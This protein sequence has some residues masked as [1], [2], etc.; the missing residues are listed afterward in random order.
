MRI[1]FSDK[2]YDL[3]K[4]ITLIVLPGLGTLYLAMAQIYGFPYGEQVL[5]TILAVDVVLGLLL[6]FVNYQYKKEQGGN[7]FAALKLYDIVKWA[8]QVAL[9][10]IGA[11]YVALANIWGLPYADQVVATIVAID[12]FLG[13]IVDYMSQQYAKQPEN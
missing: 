10:A 5:P 2:T 1:Q 9:P 13:L 7:Y 4:W 3:V 8:A 11:L 12:I 6:E